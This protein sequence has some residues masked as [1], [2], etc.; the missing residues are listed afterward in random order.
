MPR[1][2]PI[3]ARFPETRVVEM[4]AVNPVSALSIQGVAMESGIAAAWGQRL[5]TVPRSVTGAT[6]AAT[7]SARPRSPVSVVLWI[8]ADA[9][10]VVAVKMKLQDVLI[11]SVKIVCA[12]WTRLVARQPGTPNAVV[13]P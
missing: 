5:W 4:I 13:Q 3:V 10:G 7:V 12:Q 8:V 2:F 1:L 6:I 9:T 11:P